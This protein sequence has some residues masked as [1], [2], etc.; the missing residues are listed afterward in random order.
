MYS[1]ATA[2]KVRSR[3]FIVSDLCVIFS[4]LVMVRGLQK[5]RDRYCSIY[6]R[7]FCSVCMLNTYSIVVNIQKIFITVWGRR[8][9]Q[10]KNALISSHWHN[11]SPM[12]LWASIFQMNWFFTFSVFDHQSGEDFQG[13]AS[14]RLSFVGHKKTSIIRFWWSLFKHI[15]ATVRNWHKLRQKTIKWVK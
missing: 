7:T 6:R 3:G 2:F 9:V 4:K 5:S 12:Q 1:A 11:S 8:L 13:F 10:Q 15:L 14:M